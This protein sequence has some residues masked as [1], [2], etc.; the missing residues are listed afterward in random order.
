MA[1]LVTLGE[2]L[3]E[4]NIL[5]AGMYTG[6]LNERWFKGRTHE[7]CCVSWQSDNL[8]NNL[9]YLLKRLYNVPAKDWY[10]GDKEKLN[11]DKSRR[12]EINTKLNSGFDIENRANSN[13]D[14][15]K[16]VALWLS[17]NP[18]VSCIADMNCAASIEEMILKD[19]NFKL[20]FNKKGRCASLNQ[21]IE[22]V[23]NIMERISGVAS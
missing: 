4:D 20:P 17:V 22:T 21:D 8:D 2:Q 9:N 18:F 3:P 19:A 14:S 10:V 5:Y 23:E 11:A 15:D 7:E 13:L 1:Y 16:E 12:D 6:T